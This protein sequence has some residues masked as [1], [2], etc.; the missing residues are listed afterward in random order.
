M[1]L[2]QSTPNYASTPTYEHR[3]RRTT[4]RLNVEYYVNQKF[5]EEARNPEYKR[6]AEME[7]D[8]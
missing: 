3:I 4:P 6:R 5:M 8:K 7:M 1:P 2:F